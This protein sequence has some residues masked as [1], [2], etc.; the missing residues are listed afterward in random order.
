MS[1]TVN[2]ITQTSPIMSSEV[3]KKR[4]ASIDI[5]RG[6]VMLFMAVDHVRERF[7][8]HQNVTDPMALGDTSTELFFTRMTA[9]LCAPV[10]IFLTGLS[11]WLYSHPNN[12]AP[13]SAT[14]FL[15]KRG[16]FIIFI[17]LTLI[18]FSW[19]GNYQVLYLQVMWAIGLSMIV[20]S[21][22]VKTPYW[23]IG[24]LGVIIVAGHNL[25]EPIGFSPD[26]LGYSLWT[27][28]SDRGYLVAE[29]A[30][31]VKISYPV[32]AWIGVI[33][34]GYFCGPLYSKIV[35][36]SKR[37]KILL[38]NGVSCLVILLLLRGFN[39]Y[40]ETLPWESG[41]NLI[42][43]VKSFVN[44]TKYPPSLDYLLLTLGVASLILCALEN[45]DNKLSKI[46]ETFGSAPMFF[47]ILHLYVLLIGYNILTATVGTNH[48][49]FF[50]VDYVWQV[51][52]V[53]AILALALYFPTKAFA[54]FKKRTSM[55]WVKYF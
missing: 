31:K 35:T 47:Y 53:A 13:R 43:S 14:S 20:L 27:I 39:I 3:I 21:L 41:N 9:H 54:A 32:L 23:L 51:W 37:Q 50:A 2:A 1:E 45:V 17:E 15:F 19:F 49:G 38:L 12:K 7:Y 28:L 52:A 33:F 40:G 8:Y 18:N 6:L 5:L 4:I 48:G 26:E 25:L 30:V 44:F 55:P 42:E 22:M 36:S 34:L 10:F 29:G 46:V 16:L 24:T 11:A